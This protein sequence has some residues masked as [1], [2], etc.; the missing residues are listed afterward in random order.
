[1]SKLRCRHTNK[2]RIVFHLPQ[3]GQ[4]YLFYCKKCNEYLFGY[5]GGSTKRSYAPR[6]QY[7]KDTAVL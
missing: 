3:G 2:Y 6:K 4:D 1:M 7:E 5:F